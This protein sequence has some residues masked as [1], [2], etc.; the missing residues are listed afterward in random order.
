MAYPVAIS[1]N[2]AKSAIRR[3]AGGYGGCADPLMLSTHVLCRSALVGSA[4]N[5]SHKVLDKPNMVWYHT[6]VPST[7]FL[8]VVLHV[9]CRTRT[10]MGSRLRVH[11][12]A[13]R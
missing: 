2:L 12:Q 1:V 3:A 9:R 8:R 13:G 4:N 10:V 7:F 11:T 5:H 6:S